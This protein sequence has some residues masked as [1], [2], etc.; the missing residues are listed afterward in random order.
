MESKDEILADFIG[1]RIYSHG[2]SDSAIQWTFV[3]CDG[4]YPTVKTMK[5]SSDWQW[6]IHVCKKAKDIH[7]KVANGPSLYRQIE[8]SLLTLNI[9]NVNDSCFKFIANYNKNENRNKK[10]LSGNGH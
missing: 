2:N 7:Y 6:I 5:F 9:K 8:L 4:Y 10:A 1:Q 3:F